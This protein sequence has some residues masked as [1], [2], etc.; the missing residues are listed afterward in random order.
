MP[1]DSKIS[2]GIQREFTVNYWGISRTN[3][4]PGLA[5]FG[6]AAGRYLTQGTKEPSASGDAAFRGL[7][8]VKESELPAR[9]VAWAFVPA[10][11]AFV[12]AYRYS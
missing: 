10:V 1:T 5:R 6:G 4:G 3:V 2:Q 12:P 9:L 7:G 8:A 11:T